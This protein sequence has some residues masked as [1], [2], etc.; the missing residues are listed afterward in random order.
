MI[1]KLQKGLASVVCKFFDT[2][3]SRGAIKPE[4][5]YQLA[6]AT[7]QIINFIGRLLKNLREQKFIHLLETIF[8]V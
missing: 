7:Y 8:G 6:N 1:Q 2:K 3:T 4:P 5:N